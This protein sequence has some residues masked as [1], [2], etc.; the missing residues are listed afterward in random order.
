MG[1]CIDIVTGQEMNVMTHSFEDA[2]KSKWHTHLRK[3]HACGNKSEICECCY[4]RDAIGGDSRRQ[5][6]MRILPANIPGFPTPENSEALTVD[7][8]FVGKVRSLDLR[9]GN[10][11]NYKCVTCGPWYSDKW[12]EEYKGFYKEDTFPWNGKVIPITGERL[13]TGFEGDS[14]LPWWET[15]TWWKHFDESAPYLRHIY[16]TGGE[17]MLIKAHAEMLERLVEMDL[18]KD[19][20]IELDTNLSAVNGNIIRFWPY[21]KKVDLR[22]SIDDVEEGYEVMRY[23][24]NWQTFDANLHRIIDMKM[25]NVDLLITSC[26]TPLNVYHIPKIES[27][28]TSLGI[29]RA[30]HFRF[31]DSPAHLD[32]RV[33]GG[34]QQLHMTGWLEQFKEYK[35][36]EKVI[37]YLRNDNFKSYNR[38][39][40]DRFFAF[41]DYLDTTR[42]TDWRTVF[43]Q[44]SELQKR[45]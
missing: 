13:G 6:L 25:P 34:F 36:P 38:K 39:M 31:V 10:L 9:F 21:F 22:I 27:Y 4:N 8:E 40:V 11:C 35:W 5:H 45:Y 2:L 24:G 16:F 26:I 14:V 20:V 43:P 3:E 17:P 32:L 23:P 19:I 12:Y 42:G 30:A 37:Q 44:T 7:G 15:E 29:R 33:F 41:M 28:S 18:A 1:G